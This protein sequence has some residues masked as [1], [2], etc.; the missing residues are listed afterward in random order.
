M[1]TEAI[2]FN[3]LLPPQ[4]AFYWPDIVQV[5]SDRPEILDGEPMEAVYEALMSQRFMMWAVHDDEAIKII[6]VAEVSERAGG[7]TL[8]IHY[9]FGREI[10]K[11]LPMAR[12][13]FLYVARRLKCECIRISLGRRGWVRKLG[14]TGFREI[15]VVLEMKVGD[16]EGVSVQ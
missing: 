12:D 13:G 4:V 3:L 15:G 1:S 7:R 14:E 6:I 9:A 11:F 2:E 10:D 5:L 8:W 16:D